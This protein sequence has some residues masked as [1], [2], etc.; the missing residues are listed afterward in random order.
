MAALVGLALFS[1][2]ACNSIVD[3]CIEPEVELQEDMPL[4]VDLCDLP[5]CGP[6]GARLWCIEGFESRHFGGAFNR[7]SGAA[8]WLQWL[9][10][11]ARQ[12]GVIV[13]DRVSEWSAAARIFDRGESFARSQWVPLQRGLC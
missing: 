5:L 6:L 4:P 12:W 13:G 3:V 1:Q 10:S 9:P 2:V 7:S 8:G 11:T